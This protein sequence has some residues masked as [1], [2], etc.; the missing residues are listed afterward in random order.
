MD[1]EFYEPDNCPT[2]YPILSQKAS[3]FDLTPKLDM[4]LI[5]GIIIT[6]VLLAFSAKADTTTN[7][8]VSTNAASISPQTAIQPQVIVGEIRLWMVVLASGLTALFSAIVHF[9]QIIVSAGG[10]ANIKARFRYGQN[11]PIITGPPPAQ[12]TQSFPGLRPQQS[13]Q[14]QAQPPQSSAD[15]AL[16]AAQK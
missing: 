6:F 11:A 7:Q 10:S 8:P 2:N 14:P 5:L 13:I 1:I 3:E 4:K 12:G 15:R 16:E 9:Y